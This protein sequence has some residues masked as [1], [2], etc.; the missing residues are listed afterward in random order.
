M[1]DCAHFLDAENFRK[2]SLR[3][4][5]QMKKAIYIS[6]ALTLFL[7]AS[8]ENSVA[9][10]CLVSPEPEKKQVQRAFTDST[11]IFS[12]EVFEISESSADK[13]SVLVKFK[14]AKLW[15]SELNREVTVTTAK[16][17]A[18]CGYRFEIGKKYLVYA[19]GLKDFLLVSNCSR[20][21]NMSNKGDVKYLAKFKLQKRIN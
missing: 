6:L 5:Y 2:V 10:S 8:A 7:L 9:C 20:T 16:E 15:K 1:L 17:S 4:N 13:D 21:T 12:G 3:R 18:M 19:N 11:A 14:V